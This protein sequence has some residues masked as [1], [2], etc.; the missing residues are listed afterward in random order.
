MERTDFLSQMRECQLDGVVAR[1]K[2]P[3][4]WVLCVHGREIPLKVYTTHHGSRVQSVRLAMRDIAQLSSWLTHVFEF[5]AGTT[6]QGRRRTI[7]LLR[8]FSKEGIP[9]TA[10]FRL[11]KGLSRGEI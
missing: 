4:K 5:P 8:R 2:T 11:A 10:F 3:N 1:K 6:W 9:P 7:A